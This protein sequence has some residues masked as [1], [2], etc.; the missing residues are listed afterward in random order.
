MVKGSQETQNSHLNPFL[1]N[2]KFIE[3]DNCRLDDVYGRQRCQADVD[4]IAPLG[5][6]DHN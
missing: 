1:V 5:I 4:G 2:C 6:Q 3:V